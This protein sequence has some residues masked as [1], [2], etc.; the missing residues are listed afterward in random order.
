MI[1]YLVYLVLKL[2]ENLILTVASGEYV[3]DECKD[4]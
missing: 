3:D 4:V 2:I 1:T